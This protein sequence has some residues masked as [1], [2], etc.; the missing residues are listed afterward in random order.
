[1]T[2]TNEQKAP[3]AEEQQQPAEAQTQTQAQP[4]EQV[5][6]KEKKHKLET[7]VEELEKAAKEQDEK[8]RRVLA[9]YDNFRK[10][11]LKERETLYADATA[12]TVAAFL[13]V[14]DNLERAAAAEQAPEGARLILKQFCDILDK[15][16]VKPFCEKGDPFDPQKHNALLH[17]DGEGG[18][19]VIAEVFKKGYAQGDRVIRHADVKTTD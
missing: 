17:A 2:E 15:L 10:R 11:T 1:M 16:N 12:A 19:T 7:R 8:Y 13:P 9:E 6:K 5:G 4:A 14:L 18:D 3:G